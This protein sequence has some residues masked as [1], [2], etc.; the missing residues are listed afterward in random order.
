MS[1]DETAGATAEYRDG[2]GRT[3]ADYPRPSVAIDT[4]LL[5]VLPGEDHLSVLQVRRPE[6]A[7]WAL[8]GTFLRQGERLIDAVRRS[9]RDKVGVQGV[10]PRQLQV[11]DDPQRDSRGWVL[12]VAHVAVVTASQLEDRLLDRT[13]LVPADR[14]GRLPHGHEQIIERAVA[15]V[16]DRYATVPDLDRLLAEPFTILELRTLHQA[17]AGRA[18]QR[19]TFR[20]LMEPQLTGTSQLTSRTRGRPAELFRHPDT[21]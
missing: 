2:S 1:S 17:V 18:L 8:P 3:L 14:P 6:L 13:R 11:F 4:A 10:S 21:V 9:L 16:R 7:G 5:T 15:D 19:D 12:S 20:R